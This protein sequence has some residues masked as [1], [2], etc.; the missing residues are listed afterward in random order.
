MLHVA[1]FFN[2]ANLTKPYLSILDMNNF[3]PLLCNCPLF[4]GLPVGDIESLMRGIHYRVKQF[5]T[6]EVVTHHGD[7]CNS[8]FIVLEGS[9]RGE[10]I[11]ASGRILKIEDIGAP[12]PL[13]VAFIFGQNN[14]Y[15]VTV[16]AN[17]AVKILAL[18]KD[19]V[20]KLMQASERFLIN[21]MNA[22][23]NRAQFISDRLKFH[24]FR[25]LKGKIADYLLEADKH[26]TGVVFLTQ[27]HEELADLFGVARPSL[28][29][30]LRELHHEGLI[31]AEGKRIEIV[32]RSGLLSFM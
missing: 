12:R 15:P 4:S 6:D 13:A 14:R 29:R 24:S 9:V 11:D 30:A 7:T 8:L 5:N 10:M 16:S 23:S 18:P 17:E 2:L 26:K 28:S 21:F 22:V 27:T 19:S 3:L 1:F 20:I 32:N 31:K 25:S